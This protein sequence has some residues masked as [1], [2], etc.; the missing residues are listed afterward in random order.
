[1]AITKLGLRGTPG[2][3]YGSF[4]GKQESVSPDCFVV[5]IGTIT[6]SVVD[7]GTLDPNDIVAIGTIDPNDIVGTGPLCK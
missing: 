4:V 7:I 2:L 3:P 5:G 1:M 6:D